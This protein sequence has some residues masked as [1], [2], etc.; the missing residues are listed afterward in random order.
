MIDRNERLY[1]FVQFA[2][3]SAAETC[4]QALAGSKL[5]GVTI[6]VERAKL[7]TTLFLAR[8]PPGTSRDEIGVVMGAYGPVDKIAM[9][10]QRGAATPRC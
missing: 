9:E 3:E 1:S 8:L 6:R 10:V 2:E 5:G 4:Q 7:N